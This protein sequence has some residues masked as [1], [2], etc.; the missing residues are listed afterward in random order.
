M[1]RKRKKEVINLLDALLP[2]LTADEATSLIEIL[3]FLLMSRLG[4]VIH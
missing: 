3:Q 2:T 1:D 4:R